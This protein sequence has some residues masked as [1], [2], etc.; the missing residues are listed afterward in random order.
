MNSD[1]SMAIYF[2]PPPGYLWIM[3]PPSLMDN[4]YPTD[5]DD[6]YDQTGV[7]RGPTPYACP[8]DMGVWLP[9]ASDTDMGFFS[10]SPASTHYVKCTDDLPPNP[11]NGTTDPGINQTDDGWFCLEGN[12]IV[13]ANTGMDCV[14]GVDICASTTNW[15]QTGDV[16]ELNVDPFVTDLTYGDGYKQGFCQI[17]CQGDSFVAFHGCQPTPAKV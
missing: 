9:H 1:S 7:F 13:N 12:C 5:W 11:C 4:C 8:V 10:N 14:V 3:G 15:A 6:L 16:Y 17:A 2:C